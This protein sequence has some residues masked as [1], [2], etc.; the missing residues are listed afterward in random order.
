MEAAK[1]MKKMQLEMGSKN[2]LVVMDDADLNIAVAVQQMAAYG[3]QVKNV[4]L[5]QD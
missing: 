2:P 5:L 1:I 4:L 3:R